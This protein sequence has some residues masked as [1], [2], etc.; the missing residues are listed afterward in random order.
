VR[1]YQIVIDRFSTGN[2]N[3]DAELARK[4]SNDWMGGNLKGTISKIDY[5]PNLG[6]DAIWL[7]PI[8]KCYSYHGYNITSF[9]DI[10]PDLG[11]KSS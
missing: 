6:F 8:F 3:K 9:F 4:S 1:V 10:D 5:I 7:S 2:P 11:T